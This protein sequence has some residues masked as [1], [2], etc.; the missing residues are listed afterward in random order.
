MPC[1]SRCPAGF[2]SA[3]LAAVVPDIGS[4]RSAR[5]RNVSRRAAVAGHCPNDIRAAKRATRAVGAARYANRP[6]PARRPRQRG[7]RIRAAG[8]SSPCAVVAWRGVGL[9]PEFFHTT[10]ARQ[11]SI[12]RFR[13]RFAPRT[14]DRASRSLRSAEFQALRGRGGAHRG[15]TL[16]AAGLRRAAISPSK[17]VW[18][19]PRERMKK[20][21]VGR[22]LSANRALPP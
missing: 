21:P 6:R 1:G 14:I 18:P 5:C 9:H 22:S 2:S 11:R 16:R 13:A 10:A 8:R 4:R 7:N 19:P 15:N 3:T 17:A 12:G 20:G